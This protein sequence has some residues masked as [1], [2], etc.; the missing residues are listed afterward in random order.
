M[1]KNFDDAFGLLMKSE[2][3]D[4]PNGGY[5]NNPKDPGGETKWGVTKRVAVECGF[6]G[7][8]HDL[9]EDTAKGIAKSEYWDK[10]QCD[11]YDGHV[12]YQIFDIAYNGGPVVSF[13]QK[14][15]G[16]Y[17]DGILGPNTISAMQS[18]SPQSHLVDRLN[19]LRIKYCTSL[20]KL[21]P[22]FG[23]GWANRVA[24]NLWNATL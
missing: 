11:L 6:T 10:Y 3:G 16:V 23:A 5:V 4:A 1:S 17:I 7:D 15:V 9:T 8:M 14:S 2:V 13:M 12:A 20:K 21:W 18:Y 19:S 24:D 22:T